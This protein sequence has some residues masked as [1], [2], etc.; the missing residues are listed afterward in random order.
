MREIGPTMRGFRWPYVYYRA[1][2]PGRQPLSPA[3]QAVLDA[4]TPGI[5]YQGEKEGSSILYGLVNKGWCDAARIGRR[6]KDGH[7]RQ[8]DTAELVCEVLFAPHTEL[9]TQP[10]EA[11]RRIPDAEGGVA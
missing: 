9:G 10:I 5:W 11:Y 6:E 1:K 3:Q 8:A 4:M 7:V 2:A